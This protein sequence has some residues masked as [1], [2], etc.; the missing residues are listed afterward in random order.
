MRRVV[1]A[2]AITTTCLLTS[3]VP[4]QA[5]NGVPPAESVVKPLLLTLDQMKS[6]AKYPGTLTSPG[7]GASCGVD[8][9]WKTIGC[10]LAAQPSDWSS[11][12]PYF[13]SVHGFGSRGE[14]TAFFN[15][16]LRKDAQ[17]T[18]ITIIKNT[19][20]EL[21]YVV[22]PADGT[23]APY[24]FAAIRMKAGVALA[25]CGAASMTPDT[26]SLAACATGVAKAQAA[27]VKAARPRTPLG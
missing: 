3:Q 27:K 1:V 19:A 9:T 25:Q 20:K 11:N 17:G 14:A 5:A 10:G 8:P 4:V 23:R 24:S 6:A 7:S 2:L 18:G 15:G 13:V 16:S 22:T 21:S 26:T 12:Y